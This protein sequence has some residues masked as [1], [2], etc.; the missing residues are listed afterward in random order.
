MKKP[1]VG[2]KIAIL[3]VICCF[4][5][6]GLLGIVGYIKIVYGEDYQRMAR[7]QSTVAQTSVNKVINPNRGA[8][9]DRN[10]QQLVVSDTV[11]KVILDIRVLNDIAVTDAA[12]PTPRGTLEK[13]LNKLS[14]ILEIPIEELNACLAKDET[15][16]LVNDTNWYI[17]KR[18]VTPRVKTQL[19]DANLNGVHTFP[20]TKRRYIKSAF[21][22]Q[23]LG[24]IRGDSSWGL[25][26]YYN[27]QLAGE[28]GRMFW[29][30]APDNTPI[31]E[32]IPARQGAT[33]VTTIDSY[34]QE[35]AQEA[36]IKAGNQYTPEYA[37][38]MI[39]NPNTGEV[40]AMAQYPS[41]SLS[42]PGDPDYFTDEKVKEYWDMLSEDEQTNYLYKTWSNFHVSSSFEPG[43][44]FKPV[45]AAAAIEEDIITTEDTFHCA[46]DTWVLDTYLPCWIKEYGDIHGSQTLEQSLANSCNMAM[47]QINERMGRDMFFKYRNDFGFGEETGIDVPGEAPVSARSVMYALADLN[48]V[49]LAT[50][51]F[52][53]GFNCTAIQA[54]TA[55]SAL[56][57]GGNLMKPYVVSQVIDSE[58]NVVHNQQPT[59][60]RKPISS[61][62]SD[63]IRVMLNAVVTPSG[64]GKKAYI[65]GYNIGGKTGTAQQGSNR[66]DVTVSFIAYLPVEDPQYL[67]LA[68]I[69]K[70]PKE[71]VGLQ[72]STTA[73][74]LLKEVM[75]SIIKYKNIPPSSGSSNK[76]PGEN[77]VVTMQDLT[78]GQ[79]VDVTKSLNQS[80]LDYEIVGSGNIVDR[81]HPAAGAQITPGSKIFLYVRCED[82]QQETLVAVPDIVGMSGVQAIEAVNALGFMA[83][84]VYDA[85][86]PADDVGEP[87]TGNVGA[88]GTS[89]TT[90]TGTTEAL[91]DTTSITSSSDITVTYIEDQ[92]VVYAQMPSAGVM[93][94]PNTTVKLKIK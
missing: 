63:I 1:V 32:E 74:P 46:G 40:L 16:K 20:D 69:H 55:F 91:D 39:M 2:P 48:P 41:F 53:Q 13:T 76:L 35:F 47:I 43:S 30:Y 57:N 82:G 71:I 6:V 94:P 15:G 42:A 19:R 88:S 34:L 77:D 92:S 80:G 10:R 83:V 65:E 4:L 28:I 7:N 27:K 51:S 31:V 8:I 36:V 26:N 66:D 79:L 52:G 11:Y 49:E 23:T 9:L 3:G 56:I 89:T 14:E 22:P 61:Q 85:Y 81:H 78:G 90:D 50:S 17:L 33:L 75:E 18:D 58:G 45:V 84:P 37:A 54:M 73:A 59:V 62:T 87:V 5:L 60:V 25:E 93:I 67:A 70:P 38:V 24:F 21:A 64:T 68:L 72:G 29:T 44:I 12:R 86:V